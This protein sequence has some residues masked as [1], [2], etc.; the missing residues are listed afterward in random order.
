MKSFDRGEKYTP[1]F[2][3]PEGDN[4]KNKKKYWAVRDDAEFWD[5]VNRIW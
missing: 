3:D 2:F 5:N 4:W 1:R